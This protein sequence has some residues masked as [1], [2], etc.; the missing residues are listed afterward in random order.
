M[1]PCRAAG[2]TP[3]PRRDPRQGQAFPLPGQGDLAVPAREREPDGPF[4]TGDGAWQRALAVAAASPRSAG[5]LRSGSPAEHSPSPPGSPARKSRQEPR[6]RRWPRRSPTRG[7]VSRGKQRSLPA[8]G[9]TPGDGFVVPAAPE[10]HSDSSPFAADWERSGN[11]D[12]T[13]G[14]VV[15]RNRRSTRRS[16]GEELT[17]R[18]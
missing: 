5:P 15:V 12:E 16:P 7:L 17:V 6:G 1:T 11:G 13:R 9:A 8:R 2:Q 18:G 4:L 10:P 14:W 3:S